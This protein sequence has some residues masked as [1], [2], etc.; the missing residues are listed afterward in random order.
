MEEARIS[1]IGP[2]SAARYAADLELFLPR[3]GETVFSNVPFEIEA[4]FGEQEFTD[5]DGFGFKL[6]FRRAF[7]EIVP[8]NCEI[9]REGRYQRSL[10]KEQ[11]RHLL[12]RVNESSSAKKARISG[13]VSL[14]FS[15]ILSALGIETSLHG[16]VQKTLQSGDTQSIESHLDFK[17][18]RWVGASRWQIGHEV[19]GDP[20]EA[21]GELR[22]GYL[23]QLG[24]DVDEGSSNPLCFLIPERGSRFAATVELRARKRDCVYLPLGEERNEERWAKKNR[25]QIERLLTLKMLEEQNRADGLNPPEGEVVLSRGRIEVSK[26]R[27]NK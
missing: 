1:R 8:E 27:K 14:Q 2:T 23:S 25:T 13:G 7:I 26:S 15:K 21:S 4:S 22:G 9:S 11:F 5:N 17:I 24:D 6:S 20:S 16:E 19:I 10:P 18:V 12:K 3:Q